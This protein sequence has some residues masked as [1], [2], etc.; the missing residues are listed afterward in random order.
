MGFYRCA[1]DTEA[2][3]LCVEDGG[4]HISLTPTV[5]IAGRKV[6][7]FTMALRGA[8][9]RRIIAEMTAIADKRGL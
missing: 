3:G 5:A 7:E 8:D 9:V 1:D 6:T 4:D 2:F